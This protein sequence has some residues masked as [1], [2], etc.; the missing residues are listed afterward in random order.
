ML[1]SDVH[2]KDGVTYFLDGPFL[3]SLDTVLQTI[4]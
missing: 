4:I 3:S 1:R 2:F